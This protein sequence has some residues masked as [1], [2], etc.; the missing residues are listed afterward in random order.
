MNVEHCKFAVV[1]SPR[2]SEFATRR[3]VNKCT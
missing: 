1:D 2:R 3:E